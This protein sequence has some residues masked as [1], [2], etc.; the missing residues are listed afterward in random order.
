MSTAT[1]E[2]PANR[3]MTTSYDVVPYTSNPFAQTDP[4]RLFA[5]AKMFS[6][7]PVD[8]AKAR[9][10][11]LGCASGGN[12]M[13]LAAVL[14]EASF[15]GIDYS[16]VQIADGQRK[17]DVLGLSNIRLLH[18]DI[19]AFDKSLGMFDYVICHGVYSWVKPHLQDAIL[20][21]CRD[22]LT[23]D[24]VGFVSYNVYPGW[25]TREILR[26]AMLF[27]TAGIDN[28]FMKLSHARGMVDYMLEMSRADSMFARV[29]KEESIHLKDKEDS[30][31]IHEFLE[32]TNSPCYFHEF[33]RRAEEKDLT[34][35]ADAHPYSMFLDGVPKEARQRLLNA[36]GGNQVK[37]EQY[38]D[39]TNNRGFRQTLLVHKEAAPS[40]VRAIK[41]GVMK[42]LHYRTAF[43]G[44]DQDLATQESATIFRTQTGWYKS[45]NPIEI[46]GLT[47]LM[48]SQPGTI[49][50]PKLLRQASAKV[51]AD[52]SAI[53]ATLGQLLVNLVAYGH[54]QLFS[55]ALPSPQ[56]NATY[57]RVDEVTRK[58]VA[59]GFKRVANRF[60]ENVLISVVDAVLIPLLDGTA[61][62]ARLAAALEEAIKAD[63]LHFMKDGQRITDK[64]LIAKAAEEHVAISLNNLY[65]GAILLPAGGE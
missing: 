37:L 39:F 5:I 62:R 46:A 24:G 29:L 35:L 16:S 38:M 61:D 52:A 15:V 65:R 22:H 48:E 23:P 59:A 41:P 55:Q 7:N 36:S 9:V 17:V 33:I 57:P 26:D 54:V 60:H 30:Y 1:I 21:I 28:P 11:E 58:G 25:K 10:L 34:Y 20:E 56:K 12:I 64:K 14:P 42:D 13:P 63:Q 27:H 6:L 32:E 40:I 19:G 8:P 44:T 18:G 45:A 31:I 51:S 53:E 4:R 3:D 50:W 49:N 43:V 47:A 2:A